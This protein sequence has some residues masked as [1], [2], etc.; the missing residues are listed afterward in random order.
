MSK[1]L[2]FGA[3]AVCL[4]VFVGIAWA[5][6]VVNYKEQ[7]GARWVIGGSLDVASG[8]DLDI[9]SGGAIKIAGTAVTADAAELNKIDGVT[10]LTADLNQTASQIR[11]YY[12]PAVD[13]SADGTQC[14]DAAQESTIAGPEI[15]TIVCADN[16]AGMIGG[17]L[18]MPDSWNA[19]TVTFKVLMV[20]TGAETSDVDGDME[21][22]CRGEGEA[23]ADT[24]SSEVAVDIT[25]T[26]SSK[27]DIAETASAITPAG[28][29]A[30]GDFLAWQ[31]SVDATGTDATVATN[32]FIGVQME[33]TS[34]V[35]D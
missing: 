21:V 20:Q 2:L 35:G 19:G 4:A 14:A 10:A 25:Q 28:T 11:S 27:V 18:L 6:N 1:R 23:I 13:L 3:I 15:W 9:E 26:G 32:N 22:Q 8:G 30:A 24:W 34:L 31:Y 17:E 29:C 33:Y 12:W 7:G 16:D 5:Q